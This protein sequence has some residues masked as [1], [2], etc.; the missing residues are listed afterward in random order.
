MPCNDD[1]LIA[2]E[3]RW[4]DNVK[5]SKAA[6][7]DLF[8]SVS[9]SQLFRE[10]RIMKGLNH[11][12]IGKAH[13]YISMGFMFV[14]LSVRPCVC[15]ASMCVW[16][17]GSIMLWISFR[18]FIDRTV[19]T[20]T[21]WASYRGHGAGFSKAEMPYASKTPHSISSGFFGI[22]TDRQTAVLFIMCAG[23][24]FIYIYDFN[25]ILFRATVQLFEVIETD[26]T[27]YLIME[28]ASGGE[29]IP[30]SRP[31]N[32]L[33]SANDAEGYRCGGTGRKFSCVWSF[34]SLVEAE[35]T[36]TASFF[37]SRSEV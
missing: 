33:M 14:C 12:N 19:A 35:I 34:Y 17:D 10:V 21:T 8:M 32:Y 13:T 26:K 27:L 37:S 9:S 25:L 5:H 4:R 31:R 1:A 28:Y 23:F 16:P 20:T 30:L 7:Q 24:V 11:P 29:Y 22:K 15:F 36:V 18:A 2:T 3:H 6:A